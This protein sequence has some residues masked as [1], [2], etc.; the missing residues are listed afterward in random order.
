MCVDIFSCFS[1]CDVEL[2]VRVCV[3][4]CMH[5]CALL[6]KHVVGRKVME[7]SFDNN[8]KII[9]IIIMIFANSRAN[10]KLHCA[11]K[12]ISRNEHPFPIAC[13]ATRV[14]PSE[15]ST[16]VFREVVVFFSLS[17]F[18]I[19]YDRIHNVSLVWRC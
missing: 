19:L 15:W 18:H 1:P 3:C 11:D 12:K 14:W 17:C 13:Y 6:W 16:K 8:L 2:C 7:N 9:I 10:Y 5:A 4:A